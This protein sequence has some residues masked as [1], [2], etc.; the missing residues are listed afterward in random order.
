VNRGGQRGLGILH[1]Q[2]HRERALHESVLSQKKNWP[3][4]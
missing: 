1:R 2:Q 4:W 3:R